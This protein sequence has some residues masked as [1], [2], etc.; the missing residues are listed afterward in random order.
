MNHC[1]VI[2]IRCD[3]SKIS[4]AFHS[5]RFYR[6]I[7][8]SFIWNFILVRSVSQLTCRLEVRADLTESGFLSGF[9]NGA[10]A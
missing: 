2:E 8:S 5:R 4:E 3:S 1:K 10:V 9:T 7:S 6:S